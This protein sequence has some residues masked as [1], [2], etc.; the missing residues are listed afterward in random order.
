MKY[1]FVLETGVWNPFL[2]LFHYVLQLPSFSARQ[3]PIIIMEHAHANKE[4]FRTTYC[5]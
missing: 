4:F 5:E 1:Q 3:Y 2:F